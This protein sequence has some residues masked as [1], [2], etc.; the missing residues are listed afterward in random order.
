MQFSQLV[1][2]LTFDFIQKVSKHLQAAVGG[3]ARDSASKAVKALICEPLTTK[4]KAGFNAEVRPDVIKEAKKAAKAEATAVINS[5]MADIN[6]HAAIPVYGIVTL[7]SWMEKNV[8]PVAIKAATT[9]G[10]S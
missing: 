2:I 7:K 8:E 9:K 4:I 3:L 5:K 10:T 1:V 6:K